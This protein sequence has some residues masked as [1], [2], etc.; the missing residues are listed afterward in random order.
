[1][2]KETEK[3]ELRKEKKKDQ[4]KGNRL[5]REPGIRQATQGEGMAEMAEFFVAHRTW[6]K[7]TSAGDGWREGLILA[8]W[9]FYFP[10][11]SQGEKKK[12]SQ[13][14]DFFFFLLQKQPVL[15]GPQEKTIIFPM[16]PP[17][18]GG[19]GFPSHRD[20]HLKTA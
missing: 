9:G 7:C 5:W 3:F 12:V 16:A 11:E 4:N 8:L 20:C 2:K 17:P 1:M 19:G 15:H 14:G 18:P 13:T 6:A 10:W